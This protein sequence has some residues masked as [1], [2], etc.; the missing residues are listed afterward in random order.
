VQ[1]EER[2]V[3]VHER[4]STTERSAQ[5]QTM[6]TYLPGETIEVEIDGQPRG[7]ISVSD[8]F[9]PVPRP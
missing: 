9:P 5:Y 8:L 6:R 4:P 7:Q 3:A 1:A 2:R